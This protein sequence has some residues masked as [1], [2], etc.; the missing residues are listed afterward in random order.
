[1]END[2]LYTSVINCNG[3]RSKEIQKDKILSLVNVDFN[4]KYKGIPVSSTCHIIN[5]LCRYREKLTEH[6]DFVYN[7]IHNTNES[8]YYPIWPF[9]NNDVYEF[10]EI[11]KNFYKQN[12]ENKKIIYRVK[13][14]S[15]KRKLCNDIRNII[16]SFLITPPKIY[17]AV[18]I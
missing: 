4:E 5:I 18:N 14:F 9:L 17:S 10:N 12:K 3:W 7:V 1:M 8:R 16:I 15:K 2:F 6:L 13:I 11:M